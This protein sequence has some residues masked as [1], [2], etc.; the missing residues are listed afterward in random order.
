VAAA[1]YDREIVVPVPAGVHRVTL[2]NHGAD[3]LAISSI[4][5]R[6]RFVDAPE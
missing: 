3:W 1:E 6:G 2:D 5:F 4:E